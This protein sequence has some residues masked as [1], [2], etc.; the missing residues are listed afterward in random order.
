M[1]LGFSIKVGAEILKFGCVAVTESALQRS[2]LVLVKNSSKNDEVGHSGLNVYDIFF[3]NSHNSKIV[4]FDQGRTFNFPVRC[5]RYIRKINLEVQPFFVVG[6]ILEDFPYSAKDFTPHQ[7]T[8]DLCGSSTSINYFPVKSFR[9]LTMV[10]FVVWNEKKPRSFGILHLSKLVLHGGQLPTHDGFLPSYFISL[11]LNLYESFVGSLNGKYCNNEQSNLNKGCRLKQ[12][13]EIAFRILLG[14]I[15]LP[16]GFRFVGIER[17]VRGII[18]YISLVCGLGAFFLPVYWDCEKGDHYQGQGFHNRNIVPQEYLTINN[19]WGTV[20]DMANVLNT[21][22]QIAIIG[23]LAFAQS[24]AL[25]AF[26][27]TQ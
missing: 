6:R 10:A 13:H 7:Y 24:N 9:G 5:Y 16:I 15:F 14:C 20:I 26:T 22:K 19:Y 8:T 21:D 11:P 23:A 25:L 3:R 4:S 12:A 27:A 18:G 17:G 2:G 1:I